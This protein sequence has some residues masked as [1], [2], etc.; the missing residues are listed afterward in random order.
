M[1]KLFMLLITSVVVTGS[2]SAAVPLKEKLAKKTQATAQLRKDVLNGSSEI[3]TKRCNNG[4]GGCKGGG[5]H[6]GGC[7][8][9]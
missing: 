6:G 5:C 4:C 1:N 2:I 9:G 7:R 8:Q 3:T